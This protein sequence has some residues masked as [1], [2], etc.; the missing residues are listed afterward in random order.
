MMKTRVAALATLAAFALAAGILAQD[1][2]SPDL[3]VTGKILSTGNTSL[4]VQ[5]DDHGHSIPFTVGTT[6]IVPPALAVG[7]RVTV[8]YHPVG[9]DRQMAD[10]VVLL[11]ADPASA[12]PA[13][14]G[15]NGAQ[16]PPAG[17]APTAPTEPPPSSPEGATDEQLPRTGSTLP[18]VGFVGLAALL[19]SVLIRALE[20]RRS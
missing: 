18:L 14:D 7:S 9:T 5:T 4:V 1:G 15:M 3:T 16:G 10:R 20:R 17:Q 6:T 12:R 13:G 11:D 19:G 8:H 2:Q